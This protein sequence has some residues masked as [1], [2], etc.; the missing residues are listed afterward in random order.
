MKL[1]IDFSKMNYKEICE[2]VLSVENIENVYY[3][4]DKRI[5]IEML[6]QDNRKTVQKLGSR[7]SKKIRAKRKRD[8]ESKKNV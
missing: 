4:R 5:I 7:M 8:S 2:Y 6:L 3:E 1:N